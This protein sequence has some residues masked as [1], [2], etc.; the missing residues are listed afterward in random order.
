MEIR[1]V[2]MYITSMAPCKNQYTSILIK[3]MFRAVCLSVCMW[4]MSE[5]IKACVTYKFENIFMRV[6][7]DLFCSTKESQIQTTPGRQL[8]FNIQAK[9]ITGKYE[10]NKCKLNVFTAKH[11]KLTQNLWKQTP[12]ISVLFLSLYFSNRNTL[13]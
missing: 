3:T 10:K 1:L 7:D 6:G 12:S 4:A 5:V 13:H 2:K 9:Q 11:M 8:V